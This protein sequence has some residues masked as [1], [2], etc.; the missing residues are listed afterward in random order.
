MVDYIDNSTC[1]QEQNKATQVVE[2]ALSKP[3][4]HSAFPVPQQELQHFLVF[5]V[6]TFP[7]FLVGPAL[8]WNGPLQVIGI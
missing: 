7:T 5:V 8:F 4:H 3:V 6:L 2:E 1:I